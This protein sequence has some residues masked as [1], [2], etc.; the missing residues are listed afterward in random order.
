[1]GWHQKK[2][3]HK[4]EKNNHTILKEQNPLNKSAYQMQLKYH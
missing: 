4:E 1:M 3:I 2:E